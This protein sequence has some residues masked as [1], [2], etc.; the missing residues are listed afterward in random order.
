MR[1]VELLNMFR[2]LGKIRLSGIENR[3][4][5]SALISAHLKLFR[6]AREND[7]FLLS[8]NERFTDGERDSANEAYSRYLQ[9]EVDVALDKISRS[10]FAEAVAGSDTDIFLG[11]LNALEPLLK[12]DDV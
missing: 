4:V 5:K 2:T 12:D 7:D 1:R 8:L 11:E 10:A 6:H 9:E 3:S